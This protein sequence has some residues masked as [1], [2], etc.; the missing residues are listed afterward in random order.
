[1]E[2]RKK[3]LLYVPT[4]TCLA[5]SEGISSTKSVSGFRRTSVGII[6]IFIITST[7]HST[8]IRKHEVLR[9]SES[10]FLHFI[11]K[12]NY[13]LDAKVGLFKNF[14]LLYSGS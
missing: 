8:N 11:K 1:M 9:I 3:Y 5:P 14:I 10:I 2:R 13:C 12:R 7:H 6:N 4:S